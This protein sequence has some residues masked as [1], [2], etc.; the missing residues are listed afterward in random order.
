MT[1]LKGGFML[2][3]Q[4]C[5]C[6]TDCSAFQGVREPA[7]WWTCV[8]L[9]AQPIQSH[10]HTDI[11]EYADIPKQGCPVQKKSFSEHCSPTPTPSKQTHTSQLLLIR[12]Q[13]ANRH[14]S[15]WGG[16][17]HSTCWFSPGFLKEGMWC[18]FENKGYQLEIFGCQWT[19]SW[20]NQTNTMAGWNHIARYKNSLFAGIFFKKYTHKKNDG[21]LQTY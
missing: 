16:G 7:E 4:S 21:G 19:I 3:T 10:L 17:A 5:R 11:Q 13:A 2:P 9:C 8:A 14:A 15:R 18:T 12:R 1:A 6:K 20:I